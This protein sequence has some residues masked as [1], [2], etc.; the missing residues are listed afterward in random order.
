MADIGYFKA[1]FVVQDSTKRKARV[2]LRVDS[3]DAKA[4]VAAADTT[5][6]AATKVGLLLAAVIALVLDMPDALYAWGLDYG[7]LLDTFS[8]PIPEDKYFRS[9]KLNV[10]YATL[11]NG[12][13]ATGGFTIPM[14]LESVI[15]METNGENVTIAGAGASAEITALITQIVDTLLSSYGTAVTDV[16]EITVNDV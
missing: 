13:P 16:L 6:R 15:N 12:L 8:P 7:F 10:A 14:R 1:Y 11:N 3:T 4:Y 5:A 2:E 9:N